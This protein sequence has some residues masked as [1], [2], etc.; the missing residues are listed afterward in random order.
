MAPRPHTAPPEAREGPPASPLPFAAAEQ[1]LKL[2][3]VKAHD[4]LA[5]DHGDGRGL[6]AKPQEFLQSLLVGPDILRL[7]GN[8]FLRKE[9]F[10]CVAAASPRLRVHRN[11]FRH[12]LLHAPVLK[13]PASASSLSQQPP[14][15]HP[16]SFHSFL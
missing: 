14:E 9:L 13:S 1:A 15:D 2:P 5:I 7:E 12:P 6:E 8:P 4:N 10:L 16:A 3:P 11:L